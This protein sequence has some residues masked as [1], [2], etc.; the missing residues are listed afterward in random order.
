MSFRTIYGALTRGSLLEEAFECAEALHDHTHR[1]FTMASK[2]VFEHDTVHV[3]AVVRE[4]REVNKGLITI[5]RKVMEYLSVAAV[6][7]ISACLILSNMAVD[8]ERIGDYCKNIAQLL[9]RYPARLEKEPYVSRL[10]EIKDNIEQMFDLTKEATAKDDTDM[11]RTVLNLHDRNKEIHNQIADG[12]NNDTEI[13]VREAI[14]VAK[15]GGFYRRVSAHLGNISTGILRPFPKM[16][17]LSSGN[18]IDDLY[19]SRPSVD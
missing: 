8:Y 11:A 13:T 3:E 19:F 12:L 4:D 14:V 9:E 18:N 7:N 15:L 16:G 6:P 2:A 17:F 5:R 1:M 10:S